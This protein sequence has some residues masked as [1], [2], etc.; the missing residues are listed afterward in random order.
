MKNHRGFFEIGIYHAK[1]E[2]NLGTLWRS[3]YLFGASGIFTIGKRQRHQSSDTI[4]TN[5]HIPLREYSNFQDYK[6]GLPYGTQIVALESNVEVSH[7]LQH[8]TH[9]LRTSYL[10]G[11]EDHGIPLNILVQCHFIVKIPTIAPISLNVATAGSIIMFHRN[12]EMEKRNVKMAKNNTSL[13]S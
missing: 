9:P 13:R 7:N 8:F 3:A 11:A 6:K 4:K 5:R 10:L 1:Y 2:V 12:L